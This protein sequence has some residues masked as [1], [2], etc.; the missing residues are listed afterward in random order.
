MLF[1][2]DANSGTRDAMVFLQGHGITSGTAAKIYRAYGEHTVAV[3]KRNPYRLCA[4]IDGIGFVK[5]DE[6][7]RKTGVPHDSPERARAGIYH[8]LQQLA[9]VGGHCFCERPDLLLASGDQFAIL[10]DAAS[11]IDMTGKITKFD[12]Q[13]KNEFNDAVTKFVKGDIKDY[14]AMIE[15]FKD[16]ASKIAGLH[17]D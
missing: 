12:S 5:A 10:Y 13:I 9:D 2:S 4:D 8:V 3:V 14:D 7:A 16:K 6:I 15:Q 1:R 11:K 17:V